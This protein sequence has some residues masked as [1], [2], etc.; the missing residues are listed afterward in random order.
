[1]LHSVSVHY[2]QDNDCLQDGEVIQE[3]TLEALDAGSG[4]FFVLSTKRWA[5]DNL[6][7]LVSLVKKFINH[8]ELMTVQEKKKSITLT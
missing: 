5:F 6:E 1:M 8:A 7:E 3:L 2:S 4:F